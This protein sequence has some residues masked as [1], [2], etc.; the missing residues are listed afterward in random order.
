MYAAYVCS[1]L[2]V[3]SPLL[4]FLGDLMKKIWVRLFLICLIKI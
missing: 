1:V 4:S 2:G 3:I